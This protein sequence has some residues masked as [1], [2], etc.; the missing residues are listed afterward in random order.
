[1]RKKILLCLAILCLLIFSLNACGKNETE[2]EGD[3]LKNHLTE[4]GDDSLKNQ[5]AESEDSQSS[6]IDISKLDDGVFEDEDIVA[7]FPSSVNFEDDEGYIKYTFSFDADGDVIRSCNPDDIWEREYEYLLDGNGEKVYGIDYR[8]I[9]EGGYASVWDE[10]HTYRAAPLYVKD[11]IYDYQYD[12]S[13][14]L[15]HL[16]YVGDYAHSYEYIVDYAADAIVVRDAR[17]SEELPD[18]SYIMKFNESGYLIYYKTKY[19]M[20]I[21]C[22][23]NE[24]NQLVSAI[25]TEKGNVTRKVENEYD[26]NGNLLN[27]KQQSNDN[28]VK[29]IVYTYDDSGRVIGRK[30][31]TDGELTAQYEFQYSKY[32]RLIFMGAYGADKRNLYYES[33]LKYSNGKLVEESIYFSKFNDAKLRTYHYDS[34]GKLNKVD[35]DGADEWVF[36]Y[37]E[38]GNIEKIE[39]DEAYITSSVNEYR[40]SQLCYTAYSEVERYFTECT[41][42]ELIEL[43]AAESSGGI[44][45]FEY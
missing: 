12:D 4:S 1:M 31:Y 2:S 19:D 8:N 30:D 18:E 22:E 29:E 28:T 33:T 6:N 26:K 41:G 10:T 24:H 39:W 16:K 37:N 45:L 43:G 44:W 11:G 20:I 9:I 23:Y 13:N 27:V 35:V 34:E 32:G 5:F 7:V 3:S 38:L 36:T 42:L 15:I 25:Q 21:E 14:R 40:V 17:E